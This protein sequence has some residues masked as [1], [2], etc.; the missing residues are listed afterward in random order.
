MENV[1][2]AATEA[3]MHE[4]IRARRARNTIGKALGRHYPTHPWMVSMSGDGTVAQIMCPA[5][6]QEFGMVIHANGSTEEIERKAVRMGG[7]LLERFRVS[8]TVAD[9]EHVKR[10]PRGN[11]IH[12]RVGGL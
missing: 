12:G 8:R 3:E 5:I 4:I 9:F 11:A 6:S 10:N 2:Q 1:V 7:E